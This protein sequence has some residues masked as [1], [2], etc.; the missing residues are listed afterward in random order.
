MMIATIN[1]YTIDVTIGFNSTTYTVRESNGSVLLQI[2][3]LNGEFDNNSAVSV[4]LNT[5]DGSAK[6]KLQIIHEN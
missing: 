2:D 1:R 6:C 3:L 5:V 4:R